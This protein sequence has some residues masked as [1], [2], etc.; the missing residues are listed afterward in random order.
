MGNKNLIA[1]LDRVFAVLRE[2][3]PDEA[4]DWLDRQT[5]S[6]VEYRRSALL[7]LMQTIS[8][9]HYSAS[10]RTDLEYYIWYAIEH[11]DKPLLGLDDEHPQR[12]APDTIAHLATLAVQTNGWWCWDEDSGDTEFYPLVTLFRLYQVWRHKRGEKGMAAAITDHVVETMA[13]PGMT[14]KSTL[15]AALNPE[16]DDEW[17]DVAPEDAP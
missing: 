10:W 1:Q 4:R 14:A 16:P 13:S 5:K 12:L 15:D 8:R 11:P 2:C 6:T 3:S 7:R 17:D 9:T